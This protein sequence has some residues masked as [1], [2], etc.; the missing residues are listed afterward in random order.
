MRFRIR[1]MT[2][3][4]QCGSVV[5]VFQLSAILNTSL[6][7]ASVWIKSFGVSGIGGYIPGGVF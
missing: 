6:R 3:S 5:I 4:I 1:P 2:T 7:V